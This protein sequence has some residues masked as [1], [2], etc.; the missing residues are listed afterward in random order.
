MQKKRIL[1]T[2]CAGFIG[3]HLAENLASDGY[4]VWGID[5][6][7]LGKLE[8]IPSNI[9]FIKCDLT[10]PK[11]T[12]AA[13]EKIKPTLIYHLAAWAHEGLSQFMPRLICENN[14]NA[15][16]NLI[17][18]AVKNGMKRIVVVSSFSVYGKQK[19]PFDETMDTK[20]EDVYAIAKSAMEKTTE[21]L[22]DIHGF[23][24]TIIRPHNVYGPK[25][26]LSDPYRNVVGIFINRLMKG[27][28]PIIYGDGKQ[29]RSLTY[30]DDLTPYLAKSGLT[31]KT[32]GEII[33]IGPYNPVSITKLATIVLKTLNS[34]LKPIYFP[35]RPR[36]VKNAYCQNLKAERLLGYQTKTNLENGIRKTV[37]WAKKIGPVKFKYLDELELTGNKLPKTWA[38]R[39]I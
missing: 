14:F 15:F 5:N 4:K 17:V 30:I 31:N 33:N 2:G 13:I 21:V 6:L 16:L 28:P 26:N 35:K 20:P 1:I 19:A 25:Q 39:L 7:S 27:L 8:N 36:D 9:T 22:S 37:E 10:N 18:P 29:T 32:K 34:N 11:T 3:S 24:Y 23:D 12:K 38:K